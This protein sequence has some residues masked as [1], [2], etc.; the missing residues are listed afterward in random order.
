MGIKVTNTNTDSK[1]TEFSYFLILERLEAGI[2]LFAPQIF[3]ETCMTQSSWQLRHNF[4]FYYYK[5]LQT[6]LKYD[7]FFINLLKTCPKLW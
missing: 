6:M 7:V 5:R 2:L 1:I 4:S 3:H